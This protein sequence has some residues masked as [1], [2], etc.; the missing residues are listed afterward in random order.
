[1]V[2]RIKLSGF[3]CFRCGHKWFSRS[4]CLKYKIPRLCPKCK[5]YLW[6]RPRKRQFK[7]ALTEISNKLIS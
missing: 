6:D 2:K 3:E 5:S 4:K 1:M 7:K